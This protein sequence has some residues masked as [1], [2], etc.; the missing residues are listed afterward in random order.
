MK[1]ISG[2]GKGRNHLFL[3]HMSASKEQQNFFEASGRHQPMLGQF[4]S[5]DFWSCDDHPVFVQN[6]CPVLGIPEN[7]RGL[8]E[9]QPDNNLFV[10]S[11][12]IKSIH[13]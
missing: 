10:G 5:A 8:L 3:E 13:L 6:H 2:G 4:L 1:T 9:E 7:C 12:E 11:A